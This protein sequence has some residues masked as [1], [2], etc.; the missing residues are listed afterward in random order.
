MKREAF[1]V[2][3]EGIDLDVFNLLPKENFMAYAFKSD[4]N[5]KETPITPGVYNQQINFIA[6]SHIYD[7]LNAILESTVTQFT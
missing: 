6:P 4:A 1:Y 3:R 7:T 2:L 5:S